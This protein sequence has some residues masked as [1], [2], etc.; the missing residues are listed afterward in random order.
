MT[1]INEEPKTILKV[2][3]TDLDGTL[4]PLP[5]SKKNQAALVKI[6]EAVKEKKFNL[7][8]CTGRH[9]TSVADAQ[10]EFS[11]PEPEWII[12]DVGT[13][14]H[15]N[16]NGSFPE[17][18]AYEHHLSEMTGRTSREEIESLLEGLQGLMLQQEDHQ[19]PFKISY[20]CASD[21]TDELVER[22]SKLLHDFRI[23]YEA[24]GSIDPFLNCGLIDLLPSGVS[25]A[26]ALKW[27]AEYAGY[28]PGDVVYA[29]DSGNDYPALISGC[30]A[31]LV[32]NASKGLPQKVRK[33]LKAKK[34]TRNLFMATEKA[35]SGVLQGLQN[36]GFM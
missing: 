8:F 26:Y 35:T 20:E 9:F 15:H 7:I 29:G 33:A 12:C 24:S 10:V 1:K 27:L 28:G 36:Y 14:I 23:P 16:E 30:R 21:Q 32:A 3:A 5:D 11:L 19:R 13:S 6:S 2:L 31:I 4:I 18:S 22:I 17:F 25:K 34:K